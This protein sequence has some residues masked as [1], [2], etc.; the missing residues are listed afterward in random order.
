MDYNTLLCVAVATA[1]T[2]TNPQHVD[3]VHVSFQR[4]LGVLQL[5]QLLKD[6]GQL[7]HLA[8][9]DLAVWVHAIREGRMQQDQILKV[10]TWK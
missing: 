8:Q 9:V 5:H 1:A 3:Q 10:Y 7:G 6:D 4:R 2:A